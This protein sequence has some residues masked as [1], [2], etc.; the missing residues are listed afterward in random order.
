[1]RNPAFRIFVLRGMD[2]DSFERQLR[3]LLPSA[4]GYAVRLMNGNREEAADLVQEAAIAAFRGRETFQPGTYFKPWFFKILTHSFYRRGG[5]KRLQTVPLDIQDGMTDIPAEER[6]VDPE[7]DAASRLILEIEADQVR[8]ALDALPIE[9]RE[10]SALYFAAEM[11][12]EQIAETLEI[13][14][15]TVRSRLHRARRILQ[16]ELKELAMSRNWRLAA[17]A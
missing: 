4:Y 10:V 1:M 11:S 16:S 9:F 17:I 3:E 15:G 8:R 7:I 13:P 12:Y 2:R 5:R 6:V 14:L